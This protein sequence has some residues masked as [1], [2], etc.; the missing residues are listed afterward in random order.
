MVGLHPAPAPAWLG[1]VL[2]GAAGWVV[3]NLV[4][5]WVLPP[6]KEYLEQFR[7][8]LFPELPRGLGAS[9]FLFA[10]TPGGLRGGRCSAA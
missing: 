1:A 10:F 8:L 7:K 9:L 2:M 4:A 6:P 5:Q 3:A